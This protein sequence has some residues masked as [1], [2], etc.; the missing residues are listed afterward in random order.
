MECSKHPGRGINEQ[1]NTINNIKAF[2]KLKLSGNYSRETFGKIR[3]P[4]Y[5]FGIFLD[6]L[7]LTSP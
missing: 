2:M 1:Q 4:P 3:S 6:Q 7:F 5:C